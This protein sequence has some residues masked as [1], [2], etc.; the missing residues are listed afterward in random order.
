[1]GPCER[2]RKGSGGGTEAII[3]RSIIC[4][5]SGA[6]RLLC[7]LGAPATWG[8]SLGWRRGGRLGQADVLVEKLKRDMKDINRGLGTQMVKNPPS[9]QENPG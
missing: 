5:V 4:L 6:Q 7:A 2:K 3:S 1:M 9:M 8:S